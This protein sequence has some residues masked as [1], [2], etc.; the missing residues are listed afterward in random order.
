M[1]SRPQYTDFAYMG[2]TGPCGPLRIIF[3]VLFRVGVQALILN[4]MRNGRSLPKTVEYPVE[5]LG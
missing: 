3:V 4:L 5:R 1:C 2:G